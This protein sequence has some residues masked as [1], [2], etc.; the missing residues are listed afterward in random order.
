M[1]R[2]G[3][4]SASWAPGASKASSVSGS[5]RIWMTARSYGRSQ[6]SVRPA[7]SPRTTGMISAARRPDNG[8]GSG[9]TSSQA[10]PPFGRAAGLPTADPGRARAA[11]RA[12]AHSSARV[13]SSIMTS[14]DARAVSPQVT[15]P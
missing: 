11:R 9:D 10:A 14:Y 15:M 1:V 5:S 4:T 12:A 8:R 7:S 3:V 6:S 2:G 13:T